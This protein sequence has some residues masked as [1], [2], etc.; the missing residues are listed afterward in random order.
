MELSVR[1]ARRAPCRVILP[2]GQAPRGGWPVVLALHGYGWDEARFEPVIRRRFAG[3]PWVWL[4][5]R[6]PYRVHASPGEVG[7]A[8]LVGSREHPDHEGMQETE[9]YLRT[10]LAL[11]RRRLPVS[12]RTAVLGF[13][14]GGFTAGVAALRHPKRYRAAAVLGAY[15]N[16]LMVPKGLTS[17]QG[18]R[19]AFFHGRQDRDVPPER[20]RRSV[21]ALAEA[22]IPAPL[23]TFP[24][25]HKLSPAMAGAA[26][27]FL[28]ASL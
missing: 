17:A 3:T 25:G 11:A 27:A 9:R 6:G 21:A 13:S 12:R 26:R 18:A 19:L 5:P 1:V 8:W 4:V 24:G 7:Y 10:L 2:R 14:Q 28:E 23:A 16:P 20:A 22:G 15:I